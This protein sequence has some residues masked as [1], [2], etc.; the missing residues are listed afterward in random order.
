MHVSSYSLNTAY[1]SCV[2][3]FSRSDLILIKLFH[4]KLNMI[5]PLRSLPFLNSRISSLPPELPQSFNFQLELPLL[6][7][8]SLRVSLNRAP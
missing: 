3:R 1:F 8:A 4:D 7:K 2:F 5:P 6:D